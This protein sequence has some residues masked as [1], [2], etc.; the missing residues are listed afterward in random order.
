MAEQK[1]LQVGD[2]APDFT[3]K[4]H[5]NKEFR[6]SD[7][8]GK[9]VLLA[10]HPLAFTPVCA[11]HMKS[12]EDKKEELEQLNTVAVGISVDPIPSKHS[13]ARDIEVKDTLLLSDF[14]AHGEVAKLFGVFREQEGFSER[15]H[16][17]IDE[18]G[19]II[20]MKIYD[21]PEVP[22]MN[23]IIDFLKSR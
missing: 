23:E 1:R 19:T 14:W 4:D 15:A 3:L 9:K 7:L 16:I 21:I 22:D 18:E 8:R 20:F 17:I 13:W 5:H 10:F 11:K 6:L 12:L 2:K